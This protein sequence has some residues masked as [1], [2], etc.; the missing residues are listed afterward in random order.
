MA[1]TDA[2]SDLVTGKRNHG[3]WSES[4]RRDGTA[5]ITD[6]RSGDTEEDNEWAAIQRLPTFERMR[7]GML[8]VVLDNGKLLSYQVDVTNLR[9]Q[10]RKQL[11]ESVL[12]FVEEDHDKFLRRLR[13]RIDRCVPLSFIV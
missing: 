5:E 1:S 2:I 7:K 8:S 9:L 3:N 13:D 12:K 11:L 4:Y 10:D 6:I